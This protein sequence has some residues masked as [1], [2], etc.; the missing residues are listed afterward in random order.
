MW[1][2][3]LHARAIDEKLRHWIKHAS[4]DNQ[5]YLAPLGSREPVAEPELQ[6]TS[7]DRVRL[8]VDELSRVGLPAFGVDH[9]R[10]DVLLKTARAIVPG[11]RH[12]WNRRAP[13]RLYDVPVALG[14]LDYPL[15]EEELNS[16]CCMI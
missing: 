3:I 16:I 6:L 9:S 8:I 4:L 2:G 10:A 12:V 14:W 11:L 7:E 15:S 1:F 5:P 13:G